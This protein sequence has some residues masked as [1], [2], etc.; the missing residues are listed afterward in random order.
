MTTDTS[1]AC[2]R[3]GVLCKPY[4]TY[5]ERIFSFESTARLNSNT[6]SP[7]CYD[8]QRCVNQEKEN[9]NASK[10]WDNVMLLDIY[11]VEMNH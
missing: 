4:N 11:P 8:L 5:T 1:F 3:L 6:I 2:P 7:I 10:A 9:E